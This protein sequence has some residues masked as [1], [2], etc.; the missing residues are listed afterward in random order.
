[1]TNPTIGGFYLSGIPLSQFSLLCSAE[2]VFHLHLSGRRSLKTPKT[3]KKA[4]KQQRI[5]ERLREELATALAEVQP[6]FAPCLPH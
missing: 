4:V 5:T 1:M 3:L 2:G 6:Q